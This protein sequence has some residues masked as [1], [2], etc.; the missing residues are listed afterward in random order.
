MDDIGKYI[1]DTHQLAQELLVAAAM[2]EKADLV[3]IAGRLSAKLCTTAANDSPLSH[4]LLTIF[5]NRYQP[6]AQ[7]I[8]K[9]GSLTALLAHKLGFQETI[10]RRLVCAAITMDLSVQ[11]IIQARVT[12]GKFSADLKTRWRKHPVLSFALL[13]KRGVTDSIWLSHVLQHHERLNGSGFP[14]RI[15]GNALLATAPLLGLVSDALELLMPTAKRQGIAPETVMARLYWRRH[16]YH[17]SHLN[18]LCELFQP[19]PVGAQLGLKRGGIALVVRKP[20]SNYV[21]AVKHYSRQGVKGVEVIKLMAHDIARVYPMLKV[22]KMDLLELW[23]EGHRQMSNS[24]SKNWP[25]PTLEPSA[26]KVKLSQ[27]LNQENPNIT[28][29][30]EYIESEPL[31]TETLFKMANREIDTAKPTRA[32][33]HAIMM[34]GLD[35]LAPMLLRSDLLGQCQQRRFPM[36]HWVYQYVDLFAEC[37]AQLATQ[38]YF[39]M[40][41]QA[42]TLA[43]FAVAGWFSDEEMSNRIQLKDRQQNELELYSVFE[44][45]SATPAAELAEKGLNAARQ[46]KLPFNLLQSLEVFADEYLPEEVPLKSRHPYYLLVLAGHLMIQLLNKESDWNERTALMTRLDI[47]NK[48]FNEARD[49]VLACGSAFCPLPNG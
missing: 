20:V 6:A 12:T 41:E 35:R 39:M 17:R 18:A 38:S 21:W 31:L 16:C 8:V 10:A 30:S 22:D 23:L 33:K 7:W 13:R 27:L 40:P 34:I 14:S 42:R 25:E 15:H 36:D 9:A 47:S 3:A 26:L 48:Q 49:A 37:A 1:S 29:I 32:I 28:K 45:L 44:L 24:L 4:S 5:S 43:T 11:D 46:W 19:L 2:P